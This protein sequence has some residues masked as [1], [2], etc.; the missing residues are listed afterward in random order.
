MWIGNVYI[1]IYYIYMYIYIYTVIYIYHASIKSFDPYFSL[2]ASSIPTGR[3][4]SVKSCIVTI[5]ITKILPPVQTCLFYFIFFCWFM[6]P[7]QS[8]HCIVEFFPLPSFPNTFGIG[9]GSPQILTH[10]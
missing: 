1:Y 6:Y 8:F 9:V 5:E 7:F 3:Q 10:F 4:G 2:I